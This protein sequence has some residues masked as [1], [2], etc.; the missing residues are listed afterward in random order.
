VKKIKITCSLLLLKLTKVRLKLSQP[1]TLWA[2]EK[3]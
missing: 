2:I 3:E 1:S